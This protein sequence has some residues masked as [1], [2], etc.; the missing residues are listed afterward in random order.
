MS[1]P[2]TVYCKCRKIMAFYANNTYTSNGLSPH[3]CD[4]QTPEMIA[5]AWVT[6]IASAG[7]HN[8][9]NDLILNYM[10]AKIEQ[11]FGLSANEDEAETKQDQLVNEFEAN[12]G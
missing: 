2:R 10:C 11:E 1:H 4:Q 8:Y 6:G 5:V 3:Y 9:M 7:G 12:N